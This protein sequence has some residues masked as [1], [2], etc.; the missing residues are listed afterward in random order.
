MYE[1]KSAVSIKVLVGRKGV[2]KL[3]KKDLVG[4]VIHYYDKIGVAIVR[5]EKSLKA[6]DSV[7]LVKGDNEFKQTVE[8]MQVEH[9]QIPQGKKGDEVGIKVEQPTKEGTLVYLA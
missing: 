3:D 6:G 8:S 2:R 5:L 7:K 9:A 1:Y 4:K